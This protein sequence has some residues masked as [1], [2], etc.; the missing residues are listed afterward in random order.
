MINTVLRIFIKLLLRLRYRIRVRGLE[1]IA[2]GG[3][4]GT[5]FLPNHPALIDPVIVM[6]YLHRPFAPRVLADKDQVDRL[7]VRWLV[8]RAGAR[9]VP[10]LRTYGPAARQEVEAVVTECVR[11][12]QAGQNLLLYPSGHLYRSRHEDLRGNS[13]V[14]SILRRFPDAR[15]VLVRTRGL[16]GSS[17][18]LAGGQFPHIGQLL[19][20]HLLRLLQNFI[21]FSPRRDVT[22]E[23]W[24]PG[25]LPRQAGRNELNACLERFYNADAPP[26]TYVPYT[27]WERAGVQTRPDPEWGQLAGSP[28]QVPETTRQLVLARLRELTGLDQVS[29]EQRLAQDLGLDSLAKAELVLWLSREFGFAESDVDAL[30]TVGDVLLAARGQAVVTRAVE[31]K[32]VPAAWFRPRSAGRATV[33]AGSTIT[34]V[35]LR[36]ARLDPGK[37]VIADQVRGAKSYRD[38]VTAILILRPFIA[39]LPGERVGILMPASVGASVVYLA[40]LFAGKVPVMVNW[41]TGERNIRHAL[42][43]AGVERILT[44]QAL[45]S[46]LTSL[47]IDLGVLGERFEYLEHWA[48]RLS[49]STKLWAWLR[50]RLS[51]SALARAR[52]PD[53]AV[54]LLTSGSETLPKAVPLTHANLLANI[55]DVMNVIAVRRNDGL[56]GFLPPF[57]SF[58]LTVTLLLPLLVGVRAVYHANPTEAWVLARLI[59]AYRAT[60]ICGTPTFLYGLVRA[61]TADQLASLRLAVT[62]AEKCPERTYQA[63][64]ERCPKAVVLEGYGVTECSP[65]VSANREDDPRPGTIGKV[66]P[67]LESAIV[68]VDTGQRVAPGAA[69]LLLVRGPSVF[70]G[71]LGPDV[72][73]PFVEFEGQTWYRT[74]DLVSADEDGVLTFRGRLKRFVKLGGEMISLPAIEAVLEQHY[75]TD[76]DE[77]PVLAVVPTPDDE[78]PELVLFTVREVDRASV[79]R[80]I[81]AAGLSALHNLTRVIRLEQLPVLGTG[82]TDYRAL[83][84]M[85]KAN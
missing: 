55:R 17:F 35:F 6:A 14:E 70:G 27:I 16:W 33:P 67:S 30:Q 69:G 8:R 77:G 53:T 32:P 75:A 78:H 61:A 46:R 65:I 68:D 44:A 34:E 71:Y 20:R 5:L 49:I 64:A 38:L 51:W 83:R 13:A 72:A 2:R 31:L 57:H 50:S 7:F 1:A 24:E 23:L 74:G 21:F 37:I 73:A 47:G 19:L 9:L 85:L 3:G 22:M 54:V 45:V 62:G 60:L 39:A 84:E 56:I 80:H 4:R 82:K 66:L 15:V 41:T 48:Q 52:V 25:D 43:L 18:S 76:A 12:L 10:D 29:D 81:R 11:D 63:L 26:N 36:Q 40:T 42:D 58:G 59:E 28:A 79:N